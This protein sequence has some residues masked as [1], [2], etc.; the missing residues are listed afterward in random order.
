M[1]REEQQ[2][3]AVLPDGMA[4]QE[5]PIAYEFVSGVESP[6]LARSEESLGVWPFEKGRWT[7]TFDA[8]SATFVTKSMSRLDSLRTWRMVHSDRGCRS[9]Q[10]WQFTS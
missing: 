9:P 10:D 3:H 8:C 2:R 7:A 4:S 5:R 6:E 1:I